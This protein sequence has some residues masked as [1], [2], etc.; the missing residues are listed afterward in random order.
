M[1]SVICKTARALQLKITSLILKGNEKT[2]LTRAKTVKILTTKLI[3]R[4]CSSNLQE[5]PIRK[6]VAR[7]VKLSTFSLQETE[8]NVK[9][10]I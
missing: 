7:D 1:N 4:L 9:V 2:S 6:S 10:E 5:T 8:Q 3:I